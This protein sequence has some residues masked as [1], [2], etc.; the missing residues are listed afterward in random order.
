[1]EPCQVA[2]GIDWADAQ[3]VV[4]L[5]DHEHHT[6]EMQTLE[7]TG[8]AIA[9]WAHAVHRRFPQARIGVCLEQTRGALIYALQK[10]PFLILVPVNPKQ[11][12]RFREALYPAGS[13]DDPGDAQLLAELLDKHA[14]H[15]RPWKA[16]S[17]DTRLLTLL[18][19]DRRKL[20]D[21]RTSR[22]NRVTSA[23]KEYFPEA[24]QLVST[25]QS[26]LACAFL[27]R[28]PSLQQLQAA[29]EAD[30]RQCYRE[31]GRCSQQQLAER[32]ALI[33]TA[34]PLTHDQAIV[35]SRALLVQATMRQIAALS[36]AIQ[37]YDRRI[38]ELFY[39]HADHELFMSF[40]GAGRTIGPRLLT[41]LGTDRE[42]FAD[43]REVSTFG[44]IAPVTKKS[45]KSH[46][47]HRRWACNT[48]VLQTFFEF[49]A[50]SI[51]FSAWARAY[52]TMMKERTGG[53]QASVRALAF[54][55]IRI[56]TRCWKDRTLYDEQC[57]L[58]ALRKRHSPVLK[59]IIELPQ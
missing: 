9:C 54:K 19:E 8:A 13:K 46:V 20:V 44:G 15:L 7:Q 50:H 23:L 26:P 49:A 24:L 45:G 4:C 25:L 42:R 16:E 36:D 59:H 14:E 39:R 58:E 11:L 34:V 37:E 57:Y 40:P 33:Q 56:I 32:L 47:V 21:E 2:I 52:Y 48:F 22:T 3:H 18:N 28:W 53:H 55:W 17:V 30:I 41:A 38:A 31:H 29:P 27:E 12:A 1:M 35:V 6:Q 10:Y 51:K 43:A 5:V